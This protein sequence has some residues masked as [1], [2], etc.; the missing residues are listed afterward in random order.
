MLTLPPSPDELR[1]LQPEV[2][3]GGAALGATFLWLGN[4]EYVL[5][6]KR[7]VERNIYVEVMVVRAYCRAGG[8]GVE[9]GH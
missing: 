9:L 1:D 5:R 6:A 2:V 3:G 4:S 7:R 8:F